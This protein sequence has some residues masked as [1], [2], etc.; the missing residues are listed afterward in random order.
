LLCESWIDPFAARKIG[1]KTHQLLYNAATG[2][3]I[4]STMPF[5]AEALS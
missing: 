5:E 4:A 2:P 1:G 3:T